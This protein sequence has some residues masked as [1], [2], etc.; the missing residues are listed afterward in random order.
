MYFIVIT[1]EQGSAASFGEISVGID[2]WRECNFGHS[3][4]TLPP[5]CKVAIRHINGKVVFE[6]TNSG[7]LLKRVFSKETAKEIMNCDDIL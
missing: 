6:S 7:E 5:G 4:C 2:I 3:Q 1:V